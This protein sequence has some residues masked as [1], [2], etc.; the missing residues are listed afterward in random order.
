[1]KKGKSQMIYIKVEGERGES[2]LSLVVA[3][4]TM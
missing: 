2:A 4:C 3:V 1:M